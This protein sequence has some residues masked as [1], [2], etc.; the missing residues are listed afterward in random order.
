MG[1]GAGS[2]GASLVL[3]FIWEVLVLGS[4]VKLGAHFTPSPM[5]LFILGCLGFGDGV[6][7]VM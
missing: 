4:T 2:T 6:T 3:L 5:S 7:Q 1:I